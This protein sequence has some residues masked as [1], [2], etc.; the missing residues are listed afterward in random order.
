[1]RVVRAILIAFVVFELADTYVVSSVSTLSASMEPTIRKG[2][3][4]VVLP[5]AYGLLKPFSGS[6]LA[7]GEPRRGDI[8]LVRPPSALDKSWPS[9]FLSNVLDFFTLRRFGRSAVDEAVIKRVVAL[10]GDSV[11]MDGFVIHVRAKGEAHFLT[12]H[13][14]SGR[15]YDV[16]TQGLPDGWD[17]SLPLSGSFPEFTLA[18]G[19]FFVIGDNRLSYADSRFFGLVSADDIQGKVVLR[20]WPLGRPELR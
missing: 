8:V 6:R 1:M 16:R 20:Y 7:V 17:P 14:V 5:G 3:R 2:E 10:P 13:E 12:E 19:Q 15:A 18:D 11:R 4:L 9:R